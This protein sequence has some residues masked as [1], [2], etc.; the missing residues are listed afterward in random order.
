MAIK[1]P[2]ERRQRERFL[3]QFPVTVLTSG[4]GKKRVL[5]HGCLKDLSDR[6]AR[7][8]LDRGLEIDAKVHLEIHFQNLEGAVTTIRFPGKVE[9]VSAVTGYEVAVSFVRAGSIIR[10]K[11]RSTQRLTSVQKCASGHWIN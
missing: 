5:G 3:L 10:G 6:G 9:R 7:F 1:P 4:P 2:K 11:T 8:E